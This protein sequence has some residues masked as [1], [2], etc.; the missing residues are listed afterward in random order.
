[1]TRNPVQR[2]IAVY[3]GS[4][5][6]QSAPDFYVSEAEALGLCAQA[7][8]YRFGRRGR[9]L[10]ML[11][12]HVCLGTP[13]FRGRDTSCRMGE[14]VIVA[15]AAGSKYA[16]ALTRGWQPN[17]AGIAA[18]SATGKPTPRCSSQRAACGKYRA[19]GEPQMTAA[20]AAQP[21]AEVG[22]RAQLIPM[23]A[24]ALQA[25]RLPAETPDG[26]GGSGSTPGGPDG[27][28]AARVRELPR[29]DRGSTA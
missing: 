15:N 19:A 10:R 6:S 9:K 3:W 21:C 11:S 2:P 29:R 23:P 18:L 28:L 27:A 16:S 25:E 1:M 8:A 14:D 12:A 13:V 20:P 17:H 4:T 7:Q 24:P 26:G 5:P 22:R